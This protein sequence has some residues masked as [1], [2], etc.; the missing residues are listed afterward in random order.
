M[1]DRTP[2]GDELKEL[3]SKEPKVVYTNGAFGDMIISTTHMPGATVVMPSQT[4]A[5]DH[6]RRMLEEQRRAD[7]VWM[8]RAVE[9]DVQNH[10]K[11][12]VDLLGPIK[13]VV[14]AS[15]PSIDKPKERKI[16]V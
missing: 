10:T 15:E 3:L 4:A 7:A 11:P 12:K 2:L 5:S 16:T 1:T 6:H 13:K 8:E 14:E 9:R